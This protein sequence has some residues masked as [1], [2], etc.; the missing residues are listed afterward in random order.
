M[1]WASCDGPCHE[2]G[3]HK[4]ENENSKRQLWHLVLFSFQ[5]LSETVQKGREMPR[6]SFIL[7]SAEAD[8]AQSPFQNV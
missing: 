6:S 2:Q 7:Q 1:S 4:I 8:L 5:Q 3:T